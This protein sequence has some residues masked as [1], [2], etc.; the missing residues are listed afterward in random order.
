MA[1]LGDDPAHVLVARV[2]RGHEGSSV[3]DLRL[4][5]ACGPDHRV[6]AGRHLQAADAAAAA[7]LGAIRRRRR[8]IDRMA[9]LARARAVALVQPAVEDNARSDTPADPDDHHVV[10]PRRRAEGELRHRRCLAV[11][12][13]HGGQSKTL[14]HH[15]PQGD[16]GPV[17]IDPPANGPIARVDYARRADADAQQ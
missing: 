17:E 6:H 5:L 9:D 14:F 16:V 7:G 10:G 4:E 2:E 13:D 11:V 8:P 15:R 3:G 1:S 12:D